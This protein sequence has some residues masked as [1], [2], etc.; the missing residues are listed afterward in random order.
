MSSFGRFVTRLYAGL[1]AAALIL[2]SPE[3]AAAVCAVAVANLAVIGWQLATFGG[4]MHRIIEAVAGHAG[5]IPV[6]PIART[7]LPIGTP[8]TAV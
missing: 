1:T 4:L 3:A 6:A 7:P 8:R 2:G 5:L